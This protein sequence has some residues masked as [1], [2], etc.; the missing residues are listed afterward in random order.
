MSWG[1]NRRIETFSGEWWR[2][3]TCMF[4]HSG[5]IHLILNMYGLFMASLLIVAH[6]VP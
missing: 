2:L 4:L 3:L 1:A 6:C 5:V